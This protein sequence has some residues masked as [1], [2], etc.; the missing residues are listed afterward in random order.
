M[1]KPIVE[2][3]L[4]NERRMLLLGI[5][6]TRDK[7]AGYESQHKM[8]SGEFERRLRAGELSETVEFTDWRMELGMLEILESQYQALQEATVD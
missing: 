3:A 7:L 5:R 8:T 4:D 1:L 2:S 6:Q